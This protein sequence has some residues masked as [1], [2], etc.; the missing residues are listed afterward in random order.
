MLAIELHQ[1]E[2][3]KELS[4]KAGTLKKN[5][6]TGV[7]K[8]MASHDEEASTSRVVKK[9]KKQRKYKGKGNPKYGLNDSDGDVAF[10]SSDTT[11]SEDDDAD[12]GASDHKR[13]SNFL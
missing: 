2:E 9:V 3:V 13:T 5:K 7:R 11:Q 12:N 8:V 4:V 10:L 6:A 1:E